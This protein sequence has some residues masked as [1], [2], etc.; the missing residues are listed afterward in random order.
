[1]REDL[2]HL[3]SLL[4]ASGVQPFF[5]RPHFFAGLPSVEKKCVS[6]NAIAQLLERFGGA[7]LGRFIS[8]T[9]PISLPNSVTIGKD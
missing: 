4:R 2:P 3:L 8:F 5:L 7:A 9:K 1:M 6:K